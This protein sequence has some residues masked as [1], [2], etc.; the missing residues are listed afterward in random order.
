M[1]NDS[2]IEFVDGF[3]VY[4]PREGSPDFVM[5]AA[6]IKPAEF[7]AWLQKRGNDDVRLQFKIAKSGKPYASV[8][9]WKPK[10]KGQGAPALR[11]ND[12]AREI[13]QDEIIPF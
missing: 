8:D 1:S 7:I 10:D 11:S 2:E 9:N 4:G 13:E 12:A 6:V 3:F 5:G